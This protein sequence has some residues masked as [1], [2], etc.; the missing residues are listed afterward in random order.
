MRFDLEATFGE[1]H[2][3]FSAVRLTDEVSDRDTDDIVRVLSLEPGARM[4]D[5]S[6][7]TSGRSPSAGRSTSRSRGTGRRSAQA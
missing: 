5:T 2:P 3:H 7:A 6:R 4:L 1:D